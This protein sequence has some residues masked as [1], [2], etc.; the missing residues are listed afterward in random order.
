LN[1]FLSAAMD[2]NNAD[3]VSD[4]ME[5][6]KKSVT[7]MVVPN[8]MVQIAK[9]VE[10]SNDIPLKEVR[11]TKVGSVAQHIPV[12]RNQYNDKL[13]ALGEPVIADTD[14]FIS[15]VE[16]TPIWSL[17]ESKNAFIGVPSIKSVT[18]NDPI[19]EKDR[20]LT[21]DEYYKFVKYRG[22]AIREVLESNIEQLRELD[23]EEFNKFL[24]VLKRE[25]TKDAKLS[26]FDL[27]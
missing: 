26:L 4:L 6:G 14:K 8:L 17:L 1:S 18:V 9:Q 27:E 13:N 24:V 19:T 12:V 11:G 21:E 22:E 7:S 20:L 25:A 16:K 15:E 3:R 5:A 2:P 23:R 10:A